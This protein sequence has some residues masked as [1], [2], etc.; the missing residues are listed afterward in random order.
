MRGIDY[1]LSCL[2]KARAFIAGAA[3][4]AGAFTSAAHGQTPASGNGKGT[5]AA[6]EAAYAA[7]RVAQ[8]AAPE[9]AFPQPLT[10][11][12]VALMRRIFAFQ[13]AGNIPEAVRSSSE[14]ENPLLLGTLLADRYLGR[15]HRS[16]A[17]E[18]SDWLSRYSDLPDATSVHALLLVKLPNRASAPPAPDAAAPGRF[19]EPDP[20]TRKISTRLATISSAIRCLTGLFLIEHS[21][22][23]WASAL[24]L[25][26]SARNI[27]L[28]YAAQLRAE[29]A[30]ILFVQNE[31]IDAGLVAEVAVNGAPAADQPALG[32]YVGGL[33]AWRLIS[34]N[35]H[36]P[37]LKAEQ[38]RRRHPHGCMRPPRSGRLVPTG[39][40]MIW[41]GQ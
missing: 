18:L 3:I 9:V 2:P 8:R 23:N 15:F 16:T 1:T 30:Q 12:D 28:A 29:V 10:P 13:A 11:S 31:D 24:R 40:C 22:A 25:I 7:P 26:A 14:L 20:G 35:W 5:R 36:E 4:L 37:C 39:Q 41:R 21:E 17:D 34:S 38:R 6:D 32:F 33:A 19:S 27:S